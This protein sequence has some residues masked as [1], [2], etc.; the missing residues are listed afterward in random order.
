MGIDRVWKTQRRE[1]ASDASQD[2]PVGFDAVVAGR[3]RTLQE[4][5]PGIH[6]GRAGTLARQASPQGCTGPPNERNPPPEERMHLEDG[7]ERLAGAGS[8]PGRRPPTGATSRGDGPDDGGGGPTAVVRGVPTAAP[9]VG[10]SGPW[11]RYTTP[12]GLFEGC[13]GPDLPDTDP[14][15]PV[16]VG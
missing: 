16:P 4:I 12:G 10:T 9:P 2:L 13:S 15:S 11:R 3:I 5:A 6:T 1:W 8:H 14:A 7:N